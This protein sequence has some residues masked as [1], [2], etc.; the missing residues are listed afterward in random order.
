VESRFGLRKEKLAASREVMRQYGNTLGSCVV[1]VLDEIRPGPVNLWA[2]SEALKMGPLIQRG[3]E[4]RRP[5]I[6]GKLQH[7]GPRR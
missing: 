4:R 5:E 7:D 1:L 2:W 3:R 6:A